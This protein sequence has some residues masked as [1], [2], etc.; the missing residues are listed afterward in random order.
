MDSRQLAEIEAL[1]EAVKRRDAELCD[2]TSHI[3]RVEQLL[4]DAQNDAFN[5]GVERDE[6]LADFKRIQARLDAGAVEGW[7]ILADLLETNERVCIRYDTPTAT[8][9]QSNWGYWCLVTNKR[10]TVR[11][12]LQDSIIEAFRAVKEAT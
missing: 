9:K 10:R 12:D 5:A 1:R 3:E 7:G 4:N 8:S 2:A 6:T 11:G